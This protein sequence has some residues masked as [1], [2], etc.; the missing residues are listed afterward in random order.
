LLFDVLRVAGAAYL[1]WLGVGMWRTAGRGPAAGDAPPPR[2]R[3]HAARGFL[4]A[5]SN[6]K[7][8][9]FFSAF[10]PQFVDPALPAEFQLA[11]L[12]AAAVA[13]A[14]LFDSCW[15]VAA[16]LGRAWFAAPAR[17]KLL[18]RFSAVALVVGGVW[19]AL[20]RRPA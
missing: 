15:G 10:L 16:G 5:L 18:G 19:L 3:A 9:S 7:T 2:G 13:L 6:P 11:A 17:A 12:W 20:V 8:A 4:V 1:V 14:A